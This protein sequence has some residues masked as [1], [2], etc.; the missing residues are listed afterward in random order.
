MHFCAPHRIKKA[1]SFNRA[2]WFISLVFCLVWNYI[3]RTWTFF[4][5]PKLELDLLAF[6]ERCI[7]LGF[8]FRV[9]DKQ[10][11]AA[12]LRRNKTISLT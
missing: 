10:F 9:M 7:T 4:A 8:N 1:P 2:F 3:G 11:S 6:I 12:V 5:L